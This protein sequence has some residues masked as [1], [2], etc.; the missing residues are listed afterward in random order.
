VLEMIN[1]LCLMKTRRVLS[2]FETKENS[3]HQGYYYA[4]ISNRVLNIWNLLDQQS[5][6]APSLSSFSALTLLVGLFD[7]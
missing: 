4:F 3:E 5:V 2:L 1:C 6:D 7:P